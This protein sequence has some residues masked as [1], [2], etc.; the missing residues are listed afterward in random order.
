MD[1]VLAYFVRHGT[2]SLNDEG[3]FRGPLNPPLDGSGQQDAQK[4]KELFKPIEFG[5]AYS[6]DTLRAATT[7]QTILTDKG[8]EPIETPAF[9]AWNVGEL[10][11]Q[12]K[13]ENQDKI[14]FYQSN[15]DI[16]IPEGESLNQFKRRV[17]PAIKHAISR[18]TETGFP[19]LVVAHSSVI[20]ELGAILHNDHNAANVRPGGVVAVVRTSKGLE[21]RPIIRPTSHDKHYGT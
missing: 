2:T 10:A 21:A 15:P 18:G 8:I 20:H 12:K 11:G 4:L 16:K 13:S 19:S 6:S 17:G 5:D 14:K 1:D 9:R 3:R 7:A